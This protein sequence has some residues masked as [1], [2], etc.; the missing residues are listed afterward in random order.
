MMSPTS[1]DVLQMRATAT[2]AP[3]AAP[4]TWPRGAQ[5]ALKALAAG[6]AIE[7]LPL[8]GPRGRVG[9]GA[10]VNMFNN[11]NRLSTDL[12]QCLDPR[13]WECECPLGKR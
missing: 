11:Q 7:T 2:D 1:A 3:A 12:Q 8:E 6:A 10:S 5:K 4:A 9:R 13:T